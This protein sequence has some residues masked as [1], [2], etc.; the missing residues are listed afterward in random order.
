MEQFEKEPLYRKGRFWLETLAISLD[1][2]RFCHEAENH[3]AV[4]FDII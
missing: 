4:L 3:H 2:E 1:T